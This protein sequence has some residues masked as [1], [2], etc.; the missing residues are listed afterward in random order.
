VAKQ[1][2]EYVSVQVPVEAKELIDK[3][4]EKA[5][6]SGKKTRKADLWVDGAT[7]AKAK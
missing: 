1:M 6:R 4:H 7:K 2:Y 3:K 5:R